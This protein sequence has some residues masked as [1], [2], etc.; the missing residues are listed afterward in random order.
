MLFEGGC[1]CGETTY[2]TSGEPYNPHLCSCTMCQKSS[3]ALTVAWVEF[4]LESFN[5]NGIRKPGLYQSSQKTQRCFCEGCGGLLGTLNEGSSNVCITIASLC[6][7]SLIVP[8]KQHSFQEEAPVW[9]DVSV[10]NKDMNQDGFKSNKSNLIKRIDQANSNKTTWGN[11]C[12]V[13]ELINSNHFSIL[14]EII[15]T[16]NK[17]IMHY[18]AISNQFLYLLSGE[19]R[20]QFVDNAIV[21]KAKQGVFIPQKRAHYVE[22][23]TTKTAELMTI[24]TPGNLNDRVIIP[25]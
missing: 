11:N 6:N 13:F 8:A 9:W 1:L 14:H 7:P 21:L 2:I 18:H 17:D 12:E 3:G 4:P 24:S 22:N 10:L 23:N 16:K 19:I 25:D 15:P 20:V 5:W